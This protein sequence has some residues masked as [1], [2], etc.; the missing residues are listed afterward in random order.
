MFI[1]YA[2]KNDL[3]ARKKELLTSGSQ[4]A[5]TARFE[6][7]PD[8]DGLTKTAVFKAG[9]DSFSVLLTQPEC[10]IPWEVLTTPGR[11]LYAGVYGTRGGELVLPTIWA[12]L[13]EIQEGAKLGEDAK[14]PTPGVY[15]Q[16]TGELANKADGMEYDGLN[17]SLMAGQEVLKTVQIAGGG[18]GYIPV[19]GPQGPK[20]DKGDK[21]DPGPA[22]KDGEQGPQG[23]Q[24]PPGVDGAQGPQ[25]APG[26]TFTPS[27]SEDGTL[28]WTNNGDLPNPEPVNI[29]GPAGGGGAGDSL[30]AGCIVIWSGAADNVPTGWALC[31]GQDGR[32]DLRD[33]FV[34]GAG[35]S[36][37]VGATGG[38]ETVTLSIDQMPEHSHSTTTIYSPGARIQTSNGNA[39]LPGAQSNET[40]RTGGGEPFSIMP[41]YYTMCYIIKL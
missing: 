8:W 17:L 10:P 22:G 40:G 24:G 20:G 41:P 18:G 25:G 4:N 7:S 34:L 23:I 31:D 3:T 19:P 28:S 5:N 21:G 39:H 29:K 33:R 2:S 27:V 16:I 26:A 35:T 15:E 12:S 30:P 36:H 32:P 1:L 13:G 9:G 6:F 37:A 11:T 14:D 38:S